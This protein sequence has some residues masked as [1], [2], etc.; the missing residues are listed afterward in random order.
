[1][2]WRSLLLLFASLGAGSIAP[3]SAMSSASAS[4]AVQQFLAESETRNPLFADSI[5]IHTYDDRLPDLSPEAQQD[6]YR[7]EAQWR[8]RF[9]ALDSSALPLGTRADLRALIESAGMSSGERVW[10]FPMDGD[11]DTDLESSV[12]DVL[13]CAVDSKGDH[14]LAARFLNRFVSDD[15]AWLHLDLAASTRHGGLAHIASE[16]TGFGVR[17]TLDLL[18]RGWPA[19]SAKR[20]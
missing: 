11:F 4:A 10:C 13:Q 8:A 15:I 5:G 7:W 9:A 14:I 1:M 18:R 16:I 12:A 3:A 6:G 17:F 19:A 20:A 2:R